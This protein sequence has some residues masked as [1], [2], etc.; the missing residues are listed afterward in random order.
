M[1]FMVS[2][3]SLNSAFVMVILVRQYDLPTYGHAKAC[4]EWRLIMRSIVLCVMK[5]DPLSANRGF[6]GRNESWR[7]TRAVTNFLLLRKPHH[8]WPTTAAELFNEHHILKCLKNDLFCFSRAEFP[9][10]YF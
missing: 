2:Q 3:R 9:F 5:E 8:Y 7:W 6:F 1:L 4:A 10:S